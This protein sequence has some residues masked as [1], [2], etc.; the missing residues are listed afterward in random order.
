MLNVKMYI[1]NAPELIVAVQ[2]NSKN[3]LLSPIVAGMTP[4][5]LDV[6]KDVKSL[7]AKNMQ[8][9]NGEWMNT[10]PLN[11]PFV[12]LLPGP[13]LDEIIRKMQT[14]LNQLMDQ[15][16]EQTKSDEDAVVGLFAWIK[17]SSGLASTD[18]I[19]GRKNPFK[20]QPELIDTFWYV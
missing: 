4:R 18:A 13:N 11:M 1:I 16:G 3:L 19:Y 10:H 12:Q 8:D 6:D 2:R 17:K 14:T 7:A 15:L 20:L 9:E 5:F